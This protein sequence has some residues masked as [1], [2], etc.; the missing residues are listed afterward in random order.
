MCVYYKFITFSRHLYFLGSCLKRPLQ[1]IR[2]IGDGIVPI[3]EL[4]MM[5][6]SDKNCLYSLSD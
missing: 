6:D 5:N 1:D 4:C 2:K 3:S